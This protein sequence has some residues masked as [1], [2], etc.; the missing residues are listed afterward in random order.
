MDFLCLLFS[1]FY[2]SVAFDFVFLE[3]HSMEHY[4]MCFALRRKLKWKEIFRV[5]TGDILRQNITVEM[6]RGLLG[7]FFPFLFLSPPLLI[8][9]EQIVCR[10]KYQSIT[11]LLRGTP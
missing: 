9:L 1:V 2:I 6:D 11:S 4:S 7:C 5:F 3:A 10:T 8:S